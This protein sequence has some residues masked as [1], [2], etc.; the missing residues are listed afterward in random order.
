VR[1]L[2]FN[3]ESIDW[4]YKTKL[5]IDL[6]YTQCYYLFRQGWSC[7]LTASE[8]EENEKFNAQFQVTTSEKELIEKYLEPGKPGIDEFMS[9]TEILL[10][11]TEKTD[12]KV[13]LNPIILG[14]ALKLSGFERINS[15]TESKKGFHIR[16]KF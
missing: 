7:D 15:G 9:T 1:W 8:I 6:V 4:S 3:I 2:C 16:K 11:L 12:N 14:K 5:N 13:R 10:Y